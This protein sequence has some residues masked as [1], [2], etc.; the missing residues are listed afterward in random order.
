VLVS[1]WFGHFRRRRRERLNHVARTLEVAPAV[2]VSPD[3][4]E[5][6]AEPHPG[7]AAA[8]SVPDS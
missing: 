4:A 5:A 6:V 2:E 7:T 3:A 8:T 1:W